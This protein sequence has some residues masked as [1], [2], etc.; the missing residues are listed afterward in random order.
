M[1][2]KMDKHKHGFNI[3]YFIVYVIYVNF[4]YGKKRGLFLERI[5]LQILMYL[6]LWALVLVT[7][8]SDLMGIEMYSMRELSMQG[9]IIYI[10][11][12]GC[13]FYLSYLIVQRE[14]LPEKKLLRIIKEYRSISF[15]KAIF[16]LI[17]I[18]I[19]VLMISS[20]PLILTLFYRLRQV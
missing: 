18:L 9:R 2:D 6:W 5:Q 13:V 10:S 8:F 1:E 3:F 17:Y 11:V 7:I 20:L 16:I 4:N 12:V 15:P 19:N 14:I